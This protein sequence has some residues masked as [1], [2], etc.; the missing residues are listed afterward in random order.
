MLSSFKETAQNLLD[1][2]V[3]YKAGYYEIDSSTNFVLPE[4][5]IKEF[6]TKLNTGYGDTEDC[7]GEVHRAVS[8]ISDIS[9]VSQPDTN[10]VFQIHAQLDQELMQ[11]ISDIE[12]HESNTS[13]GEL[14]GPADRKPAGVYRENRNE[15]DRH[16]SL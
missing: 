14:H 12:T 11:L 1:N 13:T 7:A 15:L 6:R 2:M 5:T 3:L 8:G 4:E 10:G 16:L 9:A